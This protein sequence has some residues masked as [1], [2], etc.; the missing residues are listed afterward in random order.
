MLNSCIARFEIRAWSLSMKQHTFR[1][2]NSPK[3]STARCR[4][5]LRNSI[6]SRNG[7]EAARFVIQWRCDE[8][9]VVETV[10]SDVRGYQRARKV[11]DGSFAALPGTLESRSRLQWHGDEGFLLGHLPKRRR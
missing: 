2:W 5:F 7:R 10:A 3:S 11:H 1:T 4:S 9:D 6:R 8:I